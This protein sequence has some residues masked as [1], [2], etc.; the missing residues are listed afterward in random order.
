MTN[1]VVRDIV[2]GPYI[3]YYIVEHAYIDT[4][5]TLYNRSSVTVAGRRLAEL[6]LYLLLAK[7]IPKYHLTTN[8]KKADLKTKQVTVLRPA[9]PVPVYFHPR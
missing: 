4:H 3:R 9:V 8:L 1:I 6:E 7:M 5:Y 2:C